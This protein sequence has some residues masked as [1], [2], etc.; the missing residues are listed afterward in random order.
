[1]V[2]YS[3]AVCNYNMAETLEQ[4]LCSILDQVTEEY[5]VLV[6]DGGS[7]D[8]SLEILSLL[9]EEYENLRYFI[10]P[11]GCKSTLGTDRALSV[12]EARGS[13]VLTHID[14]D[15]RYYSVIGDFVELF[16]EIESALEREL[17]LWGSHMAMASKNHILELGSYRNLRAGEDMDLFRRAI[18]SDE[19]IYMELDCHSCWESI[20]YSRGLLSSILYNLEIH[21]CDFQTGITFLS[22]I[23]W[24]FQFDDKRWRYI[25]VLLL[26]FA[27]LQAAGREQFE[28]A[29]DVRTKGFSPFKER[30]YTI[31]EIETEYE[32][33]ID[34]SIFSEEGRRYLFKESTD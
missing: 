10:S 16:H 32:V 8:G 17:L 13:Y 22:S 14:M 15:D 23:E 5:E 19:T 30:L 28:P 34:R 3:I 6:V 25:H 29:G 24:A 26:L 20:G 4:A 11:Y 1:M 18:A 31:E 27:Y 12:S 33:P 21:T 2:R 9:S 7:T